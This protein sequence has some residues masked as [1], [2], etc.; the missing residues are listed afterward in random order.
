MW[1][2][3]A[4]TFDGW[5]RRIYVDFVE[6]GSTP[7][8]RPGGMLTDKS[9]FCVGNSFEG[10]NEPFTGELAGVRVLNRAIIPS[11]EANP[12]PTVFAKDAIVSLNG[13]CH[14][15]DEGAASDLPLEKNPYTIE[16]WV[17]IT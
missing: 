13:Q 10:Q 5:T 4:A 1:H 7:G 3:V 8:A 6:V 2:H 17:R 11:I 9:T 15:Q 12:M 16:A 14:Y